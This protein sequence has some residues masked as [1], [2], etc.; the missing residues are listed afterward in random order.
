MSSFIAGGA[1]ERTHVL[2]QRSSQ[3]AAFERRAPAASLPPRS[4][5]LIRAACFL[6]A[7]MAAN[8]GWAQFTVLM[9]GLNNPRGLALGSDGTLYVTEAGAAFTPTSST[10]SVIIRGSPNFYGTTG[11]ISSLQNGAQS[12][13]V[14]GLPMLYNPANGEVTGAHGIGVNAAGDLYF[15]IGLGTDPAA[16][17][18]PLANLAQLMRL[19]AG[20]GAA[21][22][23]ADLGAFE[24][25]NN[26]AGGPL[27]S[28]PFQLALT[29]G[30]VVLADAGANA[31]L[32][33]TTAGATSLL[34]TLPALP[35][36]GDAVP[37]GV[38][39]GLDGA[40]YF[41]QLTGF[42]FPVG[43]SSVYRLSGGVLSAIATGFTNAIDLETGP[44]GKL[45]V[46]EHAHNGLLSGN[47]TG[48]LWEVDPTT[49]AK[50]LLLTTGLVSPTA[51][52]I[53]GDGTF[54]I[55]NQGTG[56]GVGQVVS[57][58]VPDAGSTGLLAGVAFLMLVAMRRAR[59]VLQ[60]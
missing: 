38:T 28:N 26:P 41:S 31:I 10:P 37:T 14:S 17:T 7:L 33:V 35:S 39:L 48:G 32:N 6:G 8:A 50:S 13:I 9:S 12:T 60:R 25:A 2:D 52:A 36:G 59:L 43:G 45:Y 46:L 34:T 23:V 47:P 16:R 49:G 51:L 5:R 15:T 44:N 29:A 54:Y 20:G 24:L 56:T 22:A 53:G 57:Y 11:S 27:D 55:A 18:G 3:P 58:R 4:S 19:P 42:P 1:S 21:Q 30:G 40:W